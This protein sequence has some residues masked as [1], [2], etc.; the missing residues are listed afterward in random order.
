MKLNFVSK[1]PTKVLHT[2]QLVSVH[3]VPLGG[4]YGK[5]KVISV[6]IVV[7]HSSYPSKIKKKNAWICNQLMH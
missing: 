7:S 2:I 3:T 5:V 1:D 6:I 4:E